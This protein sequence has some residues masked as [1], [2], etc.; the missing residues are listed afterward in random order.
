MKPSF[1]T[2]YKVL[3][4]FFL[5]ITLSCDSETSE[6]V[7]KS[8]LTK[9]VELVTDYGTIIMRLSDETPKHRNNFISLVNEKF[10]DSLSFH[11]VIQNFIIQT[12]DPDTRTPNLITEDK[13]NKSSDLIDAEFRP[14]LFHKRGALNAARMPDNINSSR[15]SSWSQFTIVQGKRYTDSTLDI[16][17]NRINNWLAYNK[18]LNSP[19]FKGDVDK[20]QHLIKKLQPIKEED[21]SEED[22][23]LY[24][25]LKTKFESFNFDSLAKIEATTMKGYRYLQAHREIY[26]SNGGAAH[27]D[28]NYTVFGEVVKGMDVVDNIAAV[29]TGERAK[30]KKDIRIISARMIKRISYDD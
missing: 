19:K 7:N 28:Q 6:G 1:N 18:V 3:L 15:A 27:L 5:L 11:R 29:K 12:G 8:D 23:A 16:A 25:T 13:L 21:V 24:K 30:P 4:S 22:M 26:K 14:N 17:E 20:Y 10:F 9:D 2:L